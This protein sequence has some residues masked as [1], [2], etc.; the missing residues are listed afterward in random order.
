MHAITT[1]LQKAIPLHIL[2]EYTTVTFQHPEEG[3]KQKL[4]TTHTSTKQNTHYIY[5][6]YRFSPKSGTISVL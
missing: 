4:E 5:S 6:L 2:R 1:V 3:Y